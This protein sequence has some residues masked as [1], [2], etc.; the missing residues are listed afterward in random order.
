MQRRCKGED[1]KEYRRRCEGDAGNTEGDGHLH[2]FSIGPSV[3]GLMYEPDGPDEKMC[4][5]LVAI[6][7]LFFW[8]KI[9]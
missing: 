3:A 7:S 4:G 9:C 8:P 1:G 6:Y 5:V 2:R